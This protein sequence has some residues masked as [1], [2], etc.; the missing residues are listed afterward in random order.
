[1]PALPAPG[2]DFEQAPE[3]THAAVC[4]G[5]IDLGTQH[6]QYEGKDRDV[7][8]VMIQWELGDEMMSDGRPFMV[9]RSYTWSVH[10]RAALR[11][12]L[13]AWRGVAFKQTDF[14]PG[15]FE[16]KNIIGKPCLVMIG[17]T[18]GGKAKVTG[19]AKLPKGMPAPQLSRT[20]VYLW[21]SAEEFDEP[22]F[23]ALSDF[24]KGKIRVSPEYKALFAPKV[25]N[26]AAI[27]NPR[28]GQSLSEELNDEIPF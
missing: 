11:A 27:G 8:Q 19:V 13:E 24:W 23:D 7:H 16:I 28:G 6:E 25:T 2:S 5:V 12:D 10:E 9:M 20:G 1:M 18:T 3:G 26:G 22:H 4:C 17:R 14:G 15:G 21:L